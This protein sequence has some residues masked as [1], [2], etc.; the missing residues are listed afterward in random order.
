[1]QPEQLVHAEFPKVAF[2][3]LGKTLRKQRILSGHSLAGQGM[4][5]WAFGDLMEG[6]GCAVL[7]SARFFRLGSAQLGDTAWA[8]H[9][10]IGR[11]ARAV[12]PGNVARF[13]SLAT[14]IARLVIGDP[15]G[16]VAH[17]VLYISQRRLAFAI[18]IHSL[19]PGAMA[20]GFALDARTTSMNISRP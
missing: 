4:S 6:R 20:T 1:M 12:C 8:A 7:G 10:N 14:R 17:N 13:F 2:P 19:S 16:F 5:A 11:R 15:A 9:V 18:R 3:I